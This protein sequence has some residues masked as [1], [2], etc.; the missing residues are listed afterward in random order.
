LARPPQEPDPP[1]VAGLA[2]RALALLPRH[3]LAV[4]LALAVLS[5]CLLIYLVILLDVHQ[6][7]EGTLRERIRREG[8]N[9]ID[10]AAGRIDAELARVEEAPTFLSRLLRDGH[11]GRE[12]LERSLCASVASNRTVFGAAAAFEPRAF[13]PDLD[14]FSPY[15]YR[16]GSDLRVKDL[17]ASYEY[18]AQDWYRLPHQQDAALW[19]EPYFDEGGGEILMATYSVPLRAADARPVGIVTADVALAWLQRFMADLRVG[20]SGYAFLVSRSG[21]I[22]THPDARL[23]MK[24]TLAELAERG[25]PG[26]GRVAAAVAAGR[27]GFERTSGIPAGAPGFVVFRP[28]RASGW[29][30]AAVFP[31]GETLA[32]VHAL[33]RRML[34]R[35]GLGALA[36]G[37]VVTLVA[38]SLTRPIEALARAA[39]QVAGG[40]LDAPLPPVASRDEVGR[41]AASF[42]EMQTALSLYIDAVKQQ[43][44]VDE[45][46]ESELRIARQIQM[47]LIPREALLTRERVGCEMFGLLE[48]ARAVGGD[49]YDVAVR[50]SGEICFVI[51]DV[52]DK[53]IPASLFMAVTDTQFE[54]AAREVDAPE[55]VLARMNDALVAE[56]SANMFVTLVCGVLETAS[57]RLRLA[58]GGHT[59]PVLLPQAGA[60]RFLDIDL[61]SVVGVVAGLT[62]SGHDLT[63][64]PGDAL[65]LYTDGVTEAH[66][67]DSAM[68]GEEGLMRHL[69]QSDAR[70]PAEVARAL[71]QAVA[72]FA[73]G[74][75]QFDDIA[76]LVL[77]RPL[78]AAAR[79]KAHGPGTGAAGAS[80]EIESSTQGLTRASG[81]LHD[82]CASAGIAAAARQDLDL[83]IDE[84]LA[85]VIHHGYGAG[86]GG[87]IRLRLELV[88]GRVRLEIRDAAPA[89]DPLSAEPAGGRAASGGGGLGIELVKRAMDRL[90]YARENGENR[91]VLERRNEGGEPWH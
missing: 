5:G 2:R 40:R 88:S 25:D 59:R 44:A 13:R 90:E 70:E 67:P 11:P 38:R 46:L 22:V 16:D 64:G 24:A 37:L 4:R 3:S 87:T 18:R 82:W 51:G 33:E 42:K 14:A 53:G 84:L 17:A 86:R 68:F 29:S 62:F 66:D 73:R 78:D 45:R 20:Q 28:L 47:S 65:L 43:A 39:Q 31:E 77:R 85:N 21:R 6:W 54:S 80:L 49:L 56:N 63:L 34:W 36:L 75:P 7:T 10:A 79:P 69:A 76:I 71:R 57:G 52:S 27:Q 32:D 61:G 15:C 19:S 41:L 50:R 55:A 72:S 26:W 83:A 8:A 60:P 23:A 89:F 1:A 91:I 12:A 58:S 30:L 48:P 35:G 81:W 9:V 74:A